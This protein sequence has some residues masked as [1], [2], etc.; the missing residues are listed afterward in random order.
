MTN[1]RNIIPPNLG[2]RID[3]LIN[4]P[5]WE[6]TFE[7]TGKISQVPPSLSNNRIG[8]PIRRWNSS[9]EKRTVSEVA[10]SDNNK[11]HPLRITQELNDPMTDLC[12]RVVD[13]LLHIEGMD[14]IQVRGSLFKFTFERTEYSII[15]HS[16]SNNE[17]VDIF[18]IVK[19]GR[20]TKK[21]D[22]ILVTA[23]RLTN[24]VDIKDQLEMLKKEYLDLQKH[25]TK[26]GNTSPSRD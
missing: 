17:R 10:N 3:G 1:E 20:E 11:L 24:S 12:L 16:R 14:D 22:V 7:F 5:V 21:L 15:L 26:F 25:L 18:N 4:I 19:M 6:M 9:Q 13:C 8:V 23:K 2:E